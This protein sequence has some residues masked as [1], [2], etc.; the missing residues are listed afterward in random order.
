[1]RRLL[2]RILLLVFLADIVGLG[3]VSAFGGINDQ[4]SPAA[5]ESVVGDGTP[6]D[7]AASSGCNHACHFAQHFFAPVS[8]S[9]AKVAGSSSYT[10]PAHSP[11]TLLSIRLKAPFHPPRALA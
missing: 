1:M 6:E 11:V 3:V 10:V 2:A 4:H 9:L 8:D 5:A 7:N